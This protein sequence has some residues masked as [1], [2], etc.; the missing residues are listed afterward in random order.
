MNN[1]AAEAAPRDRSPERRNLGS[2]L[3]AAIGIRPGEGRIAWL[4]F[5]YFFLLSTAQFASEAVRQA[6]FL[7][8]LGAPQL[9]WVY[10]VL[11]VI[12]LPVLT[13]YTRIAGSRSL[14]RVITVSCL[15]HVVLL[16]V[17]FTL[18]VNDRQWVAVSF[19][20]WTTLFFGI[21]VSQ[22]WS[23]ATQLLDPRQARRL[24]AFVAAGGLLGG[25][26]GGQ[27]ARGVVAVADTR[28]ILLAAAAIMM[29][30]VV[31]VQ[32]LAKPLARRPR[33]SSLVRKR[34]R[35]AR[36]G[37][38]AIRS[39]TL[40]QL[41]ASLLFVT[42][43][44]AQ[45]VDLVFYW[46]VEANT[47]TLDQRTALVGN[48]FSIM[49]L[50]AFVF[51][52]A[53]TRH[54]H[55]VL[56]VGAAAR[57][58]PATLAVSTLMLIF[59]FQLAPAAVFALAWMLKLTDNGLRHS[60]EQATR[61]LLFLPVPAEL[62]R[63]AKATIDVVVQRAGRGAAGL[64][65][66][67]ISFGLFGPQH[68]AW[69]LMVVVVI[70]LWLTSRLRR[71]YVRAFRAG[72]KSS[73]SDVMADID[74]NDIG[75]V[76]ALVAGLG[77]AE[78]RRVQ[79]SI[80]LLAAYGHG[81]LV[82]PVLLRHDDPEV[83]GRTL[84]ILASS[85]RV[86]ALT[87][88]EAALLDD[89]LDVR[90]RAA[91][92]MVALGSNSA[93]RLTT[94]LQDPDPRLRAVAVAG[95]LTA[96][97]RELASRAALE[98]DAM[99][100]DP[101]SEVRAA[102]ADALARVG[103]PTGWANLI[104]LLYDDD[105]AVVRA[106]IAA[107]S[108]RLDHGGAE[109]IY[110]PILV[111]LMGDRH[112][113]HECRN[114][115]MA[116]GG[117]AMTGLEHFLLSPDEPLSVRREIPRTIA[118]IGTP[119]AVTI[120]ET[121]LQEDR[122]SLRDTLIEALVHLLDRH[123]L[124]IDG[125][126][127]VHQIHLEAQHYLR[128]LADLW[129]VS[130][131]HEARLDGPYAQWQVDARVPTLLQRLLAEAMARSVGNLVGLLQLVA[132]P[133]DVRAAFHSLAGKDRRLRARALEYLDNVLSG[134]VRRETML[135]VDESPAE[136]RLARASELFGIVVE[137]PQATLERLLFGDPSTDPSALGT[138]LGTV[139]CIGAEKLQRLYGHLEELER[140]STEPQV[141]AAVRHVRQMVDPD[142]KTVEEDK[143]PEL[144]HI[145]RVMFLQAVDPFSACA[146][147][148]VLR[149]AAIA[150]LCQFTENEVVYRTGET[151]DTLYCVIDGRVELDTGDVATQRVG[152]RQ[153]FGVRDILS[154]SPRT[155]T[156]VAVDTTR[157]LA[158]EAADL[159]DLL[160][161]NIEIVKNLFRR[162]L[163]TTETRAPQPSPAAD[164]SPSTGEASASGTST[165]RR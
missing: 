143:M 131:M 16:V 78:P 138:V 24:F 52:I 28:H 50:L 142:L 22:L 156:A 17:F 160:A 53:F 45:M 32:L 141:C 87:Q 21:A 25:V 64:I 1:P 12:S 99:V 153:S 107:V 152:P 132:P 91:R 79:H 135:I 150:K 109:P 3:A 105:R 151:A 43:I 100:S 98:L 36:G 30:A 103:E 96:S 122:G 6:T 147:E 54:I 76:T 33:P 164:G 84:E 133:E 93:D 108:S 49:G 56:G 7:E 58:L 55:R 47:S 129:A 23:L 118:R 95:L 134:S 148:Q 5:I 34:I 11:A 113:R 161:D 31:I 9:P 60:V 18:F 40:L 15:V 82:P 44:A 140:T 4:L 136:D 65:L 26:P 8:S 59:A 37:L 163:E 106:A 158:I 130:S 20:L 75:T 42:V 57:I 128:H 155:T 48:F 157:A 73:T 14:D 62:R 112:L 101:R 39:S 27:L 63:P 83:R 41:I 85:G 19:Y 123:G 149:L 125:R 137:A 71:E 81:G 120:L 13:A 88:V 80:D 139:Q 97:D 145:E 116:F 119:A 38:A 61:E 35:E 46:A 51:Q 66:L 121:A 146:A 94:R 77:A 89:D 110:V 70:W 165:T 126:M 117:N 72:L 124:K 114:T 92:A 86:D 2:R 69:L 111:S 68:V 144:P 74:P 102:A 162:I 90:V 29:A 104:Q 10:V 67:P 115:V 154:G 159:F 127:V